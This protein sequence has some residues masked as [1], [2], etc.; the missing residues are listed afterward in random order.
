M[1]NRKGVILLATREPRDWQDR[2]VSLL[3]ILAQQANQA[4]ENARLFEEVRRF[5]AELEQRVEQ[6]TAELA[7]LNTQLSEEKDRLQTVHDVTLELTESL[8]LTKTLTKTL[9]LASQAVNVRRGSIM[10]RDV[11][12]G[13]LICRAVLS[14]DGVVEPTRIP[15]NFSG[16]V[17]LAG[18]V[19]K[20][21][22][23]IRSGDVTK[24]ARWLY[25]EGR[26]DEVRSVVAVPL[27]A[28]DA[29]LGVLMLT[30]PHLNY[31]SEAQ[32]QL[33]TTIAN[34]IAVVICNAELY[35]VINDIAQEKTELLIR[36]K[37]EASKNKAILQSLGEGV[38]VLDEQQQVILFNPAAEQMLGIPWSHVL[39]QSL[40]QIC[41]YGETEDA[42]KRA[43]AIYTGLM[44]GLDTLSDQDQ[45]HNRRLELPAPAQSLELNFAPVIGPDQRLYGS[46]VV[47]RDVTREIEADRAKRDFISTVSHEL[48]TPLTSIKGYVDL[49]LLGA[50]GPIEEGQLSFLSV[51]KNNANRLM[52]LIND[53][54]EIG[55]ID[56]NK[57][58]LNFEKVNISHI[59]QDVMQTMR[60]EIERKSLTV[61]M[62][63]RGEV[64]LITADQRRITQVV[65]NLVSNAVKYTYSNGYIYVQAYLN[66][67]GMLEIDVEDNGVG[68]SEEDQKNL[69]RR[70]YRTDNPLRDEAG[71]TG[72]GLSIAKSFVELHGGEMW[73]RSEQGQGSTFSFILPVTQPDQS[74]AASEA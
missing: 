37:E 65:M 58:E 46:V 33:L 56:S 64:P 16:G 73:V 26:A 34:E 2:E 47:L 54:L 31:F 55:R 71:G 60:A 22:Q 42:R 63:M 25:E 30:S 13:T 8:D 24:D 68:I 41:A 43:V 27:V 17:G 62:E 6:R 14:G 70:F 45:N 12:T 59:L 35:G 18:W 67:A 74:N 23:P 50:A 53:I 40:E 28:Q 38:I 44:E 51:V 52:D 29:P 66:P 48:R 49:L 9:Q 36:E 19:M 39:N 72:L 11:Q 69:F 5:A 57:I 32:L 1:S 10:L 20:Q 7:R 4:L 21:L 3:S 61:R 15:I